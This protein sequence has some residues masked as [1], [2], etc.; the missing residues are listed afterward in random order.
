MKKIHVRGKFTLT[1]LATALC[2]CSISAVTH[3]NQGK[4]AIHLKFSEDRNFKIVQFTDTQDDEDIDPRTV[5]LI[6]SVLD[7]ESPDLVVF[8]GDN[9]TG[10]CDTPDDVRIAIDNIVRQVEERRIPWLITFGN[11]DEDHTAKT[12]LDEEDMLGI[13]MSYPHNI[14]QEDP[15]EVEGTGNMHALIKSSTGNK[16]VFNIW[17]LDSGRYA[18][19]SIAGQS[20]DGYPHWDW[21]KPSQISWY[22]Q[23]SEK[24]EQRMQAKIPSLMFFHIPLWEFDTMREMRDRHEVVGE[25]NESV[26]PGP[27]NS[28][29]YTAMLERGDVRGVFVGHD[30]VNDY[31]GNYYGIYLGYAANTG[32]GTYGLDGDDTDR[33]RGA[34]V[35]ELD[36]ADPAHFTTRMVY[37]LD[38][39]I[40]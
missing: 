36:E 31:V 27:F 12:G 4:A 15:D 30:H 39:G 5:A 2:F 23:T 35:F 18:P 1:C 21:I 8:T 6:E 25:K 22:K 17:A 10:G 19:E 13:Y 16:P 34:R 20:L 11:H 14:N 24:L 3:A 26:C 32:F 9:I 33:L 7:A 37:A 40:Q 29:L 38:L 28:G